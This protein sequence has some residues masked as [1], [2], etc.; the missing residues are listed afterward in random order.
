MHSY[1]KYVA[2]DEWRSLRSIKGTYS[3]GEKVEILG[4]GELLVRIPNSMRE[5]VKLLFKNLKIKGNLECRF[6]LKYGSLVLGT[7]KIIWKNH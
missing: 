5:N 1:F 3:V 2:L 4:G 6:S 7:E